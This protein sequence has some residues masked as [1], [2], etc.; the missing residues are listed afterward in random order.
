M[1]PDVTIQ[2]SVV[3]TVGTVDLVWASVVHVVHDQH[4][5]LNKEFEWKDHFEFFWSQLYF[6]E[7]RQWWW[8]YYLFHWNEAHEHSWEETFVCLEC[9]CWRLSKKERGKGKKKEEKI[10]VKWDQWNKNLVSFYS[11]LFFILLQNLPGVPPSNSSCSITSE[12]WTI[13]PF[14]WPRKAELDDD[15]T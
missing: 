15:E 5:L 14:F 4:P 13:V 7:R 11:L 1:V 8:H 6:S 10:Y 12:S 2:C 3:H 9:C